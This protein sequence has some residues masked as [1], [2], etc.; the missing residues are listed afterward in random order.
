MAL[1]S[2]QKISI[3]FG[4]PLVLDGLDLQIERNQRVCLLGRNGEGKSTL[5]KII[6]GELAPDDGVVQKEQNTS[7]SYFTQTIPHDL[8]GPVFEIIAKGLG[9]KGELYAK[10]HREERRLL[11][12]GD[13]DHST[14][15]AIHQELDAVNGWSS[16]EAISKIMSL[17]KLDEDWQYQELSG[18]QKR[19]VLLAAALVAEPD[20]LLLDEPTNH[21]DIDTIAWME[22]FLLKSGTTLLFVTHDRT[23]L[24]NLA[25][26]II[27]LDRG[28]IYDWSCD[29]D[30]FLERKQAVLENQEKEW[31]RFDKKLSEEEVWIRKGIKARRTRN[32]GRVRALLKMRE[33]RMQRREQMGSATLKISEADRSGKLVIEAKDITFAYETDPVIRDFST[34]IM[35]GDKT[36]ILGSNGCGKSTLVNLLLGNLKPQSGSIRTGTNLS[37]T[38]FDQLREELDGEKSVR[39]NVLPFGDMVTINGRDKHIYT[40]LQDFLFTPDR[41]KSPVK[42]LSGG[43]RNRLLLARLF[44][45]P[46]NFMVFDEPTNDL[47]AETLELLEELL[48][49]FQG[50]LLLISHDRAFLNNVVTSTFAFE[51]NGIVKEYAGGYDDWLRL[52]PDKEAAE[53][54]KEKVDKKAKYL[55]EKK[56]KQKKKLSYKEK[57]EYEQLQPRIEALEAEQT[58]LYEKMGDPDFLRDKDSMVA[59]KA[60]LEE[61]EADIDTAYER[62]EYLES[63]V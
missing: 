59:A 3:A 50:T 11:N 41:A 47:D 26:R 34:V 40:Y 58:E 36:G 7:I 29:Y 30:T 62:W 57:Q 33:E 45:K 6:H 38:Y 48:V 9:I 12:A 49:D 22:S 46:T 10:Y 53:K 44:I 17:M 60:R 31:E 32:E 13:S 24:R 27:E 61:L 37:V 56:A 43:E 1:L 54:S 2:L 8:E 4:G 55:K 20:L 23:L 25:T 14:L 39:E 18:G 21:L 35:R 28:K 15:G 19:R 52:Q 42:S 63:L 16:V 51:G 5:M